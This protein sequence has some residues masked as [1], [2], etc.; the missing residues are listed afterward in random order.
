MKYL[1]LL[2]LEVVEVG[3]VLWTGEEPSQ[4]R[5]P[6]KEASLCSGLHM[7]ESNF[8]VID[9]GESGIVEPSEIAV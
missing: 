4:I 9:E 8:A 2:T 6:E 1:P 3:K 7:E 5:A